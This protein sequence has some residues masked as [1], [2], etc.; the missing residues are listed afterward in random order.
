MTEGNTILQLHNESIDDILSVLRA[1]D[2]IPNQERLDMIANT[3]E[4]QY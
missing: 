3:I 4:A 2:S 1:E